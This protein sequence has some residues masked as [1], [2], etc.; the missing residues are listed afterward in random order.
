MTQTTQNQVQMYDAE[1]N[2]SRLH[3]VVERLNAEVAELGKQAEKGAQ[4]VV[5]LVQQSTVSDADVEKV[6]QKVL[7]AMETQVVLLNDVAT[8]RC[9]VANAN[10]K[11]G[12]TDALTAMEIAQR[13]H[14]LFKSVLGFAQDD[15]TMDV[16]TFRQAN[17][18]EQRYIQSQRIR[19]LSEA[20]VQALEEKAS[21]YKREQLRLSDDVA[22]RNATKVKVQISM[23]AAKVASLV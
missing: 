22:S 18:G 3:K 16:A 7:E 11:S 4:Y 21:F 15:S 10:M 19:V 6:R 12:V 8:I 20:D 9:A 13:K 5:S 17:F 2:L 23:Q 1:L 14:T